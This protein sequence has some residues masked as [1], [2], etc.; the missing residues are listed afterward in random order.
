MCFQVYCAKVYWQ[1]Y[2]CGF[3][4]SQLCVLFAFPKIYWIVDSPHT[5][6][7]CGFTFK[8]RKSLVVTMLLWWWWWLW[9][10][11]NIKLMMITSLYC[12][13][14][15]HPGQQQTVRQSPTAP[16]FSILSSS[17]S[18]SS[19]CISST[20]LPLL[21]L[22]NNWSF[23]SCHQNLHRRHIILKNK[24]KKPRTHL[25]SAFLPGLTSQ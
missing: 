20:S 11:V 21:T 6:L 3:L 5:R 18:S 13:R 7:F 15:A 9:R 2:S 14:W 12:W 24:N 1:K 16:P 17:S 23:N 4:Q 10:R 8:Q 25:N 22:N 19:S